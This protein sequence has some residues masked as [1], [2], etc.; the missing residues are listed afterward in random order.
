MITFY[1]AKINYLKQAENGS[2]FKKTEEYV[3]SSLSFTECEAR[4]QSILEQYIP[5]YELK[6]LK[7]SNFNDVIID[8]SKDFFFKAKIV[9]VSADA[10]TGKE[11]K[12]TEYYLVQADNIA[13]CIEKLNEKME[14]TVMD[15][16]SSSVSKTKIVDV[17]PYED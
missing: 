16:E 13:D 17:F 2:I 14:G 4:L 15:W 11:K 9:Y 7:Q 12:I 3:L 5:E 1:Q 6:A 10:D 8:E